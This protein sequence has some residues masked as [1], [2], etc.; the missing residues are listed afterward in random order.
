[1]KKYKC[2]VWINN[3]FQRIFVKQIDVIN[4][5]HLKLSKAIKNSMSPIELFVA[6]STIKV[7][8]Q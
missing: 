6:L 2:S 5:F 1:M 8:N 3:K 4:L 7:A